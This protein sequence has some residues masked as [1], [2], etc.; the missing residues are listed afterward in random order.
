LIGNIDRI[1]YIVGLKSGLDPDSLTRIHTIPP[2]STRVSDKLKH[3]QT[4]SNK[5]KH[6]Q[7]KSNISKALPTGSWTVDRAIHND[8]K[9]LYERGENVSDDSNAMIEY[10]DTRKRKPV[11]DDLDTALTLEPSAKK[12][13]YGIQKN[14]NLDDV[15]MDVSVSNLKKK[16]YDLSGDEDLDDDDD[17]DGE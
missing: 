14:S 6:S 17:D 15:P 13:S 3:A 16:C 11:T 2:S 4:D 9:K 8:S 7:T 10:K 1:N 5:L 12:R